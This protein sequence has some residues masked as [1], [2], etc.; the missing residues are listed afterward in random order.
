LP[1]PLAA[2]NLPG[3]AYQADPACF[4]AKDVSAMID[5]YFRTGRKTSIKDTSRVAP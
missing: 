4:L 2:A 3:D 1:R 5:L